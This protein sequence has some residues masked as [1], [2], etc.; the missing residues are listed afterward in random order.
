MGQLSLN[1]GRRCMMSHRITGNGSGSSG[2]AGWVGHDL[3]TPWLRNQKNG[4]KPEDTV[5]SVDFG[6]WLPLT[7]IESPAK[8]RIRIA[9]AM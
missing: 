6:V 9:S 4:Y 2:S 1:V 7:L 3:R 5:P 8:N